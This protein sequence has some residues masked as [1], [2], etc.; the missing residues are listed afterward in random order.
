LEP[1]QGC[2]QAEL[3]QVI[4][5]MIHDFSKKETRMLT[6]QDTF[7]ILIPVL[8][9]YMLFT[10]HAISVDKKSSFALMSS[11]VENGAED[12]SCQP[13][14]ELTFNKNVVKVK[15]DCV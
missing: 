5:Q 7:K 8:L 15:E 11:S 10:A 3:L 9:T 6:V 2:I 13:V 14:I 4:S 12:V 1:L